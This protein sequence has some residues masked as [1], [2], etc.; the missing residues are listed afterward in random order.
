MSASEPWL[1]LKRGYPE[2]LEIV[3]DPGRDVHLAWSGD[4]RVGFL[5]LQMRGPF[6]GYLQTIC[7]APEARGRGLGSEML[8]WAER[9]VFAVAPNLF[10]CVSSFNLD[11]R[12]LYERLGYETVGVLKDYLV[13]G[14]DE[15]LMRKTSGP[16]LGFAPGG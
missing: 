5:I 10:L 9:R 11:A 7:V 14:H 15:I 12:R 16:L 8:R 13:R 4:E 6:V 2:S 1:T 3:S